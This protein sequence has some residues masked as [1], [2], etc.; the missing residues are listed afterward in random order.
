MYEQQQELED[1]LNLDG[2]TEEQI[3]ENI[4]LAYEE[5][6]A[7]IINEE[8]YKDMKSSEEAVTFFKEL[9]MN[10]DITVSPRERI[11][12]L[13]E[14]RKAFVSDSKETLKPIQKTLN[15]SRK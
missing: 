1:V 9:E 7:K 8:I 3:A 6:G 11:K 10:E 12:L 13:K 2:L 15:I 14:Y 4:K 5:N